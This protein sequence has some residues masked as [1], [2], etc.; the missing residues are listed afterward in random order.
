MLTVLIIAYWAGRAAGWGW[1]SARG[2]VAAFHAARDRLDAVI[3]AA[4]STTR[5]ALNLLIQIRA[6]RAGRLGALPPDPEDPDG[7]EGSAFGKWGDR[8]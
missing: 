5:Q 1:A 4:E 3:D 7:P 6:D 8:D 2:E